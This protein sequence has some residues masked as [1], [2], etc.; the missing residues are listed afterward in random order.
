MQTIMLVGHPPRGGV[1]E[2]L[3]RAGL[4]VLSADDAEA[5]LG[6]LKALRVNGFVIDVAKARHG[7]ERLVERLGESPT[8]R[9]LPV[10]ITGAGPAQCERLA[11][12]AFRGAIIAARERSADAVLGALRPFL[13]SDAAPIDDVPGRHAWREAETDVPMRTIRRWMGDDIARQY[14]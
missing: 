12:R 9:H 14:R 4:F 11:Q 3:F 13:D 5:A 10:V 6:I 1:A 7:G 8:W 2:R